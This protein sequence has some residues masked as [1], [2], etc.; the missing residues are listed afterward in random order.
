MANVKFVVT[1]RQK[2]IWLIFIRNAAV[3]SE[4]LPNP[5]RTNMLY[6][7]TRN[8]AICQRYFQLI[9][10]KVPTMHAYAITGKEFYLSEERI[11]KIIAQKH[12][13]A[14]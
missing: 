5:Y 7:Q 13:W 4:P 9:S 11:R 8:K 6:I 1:I 2:Q 3:T 14:K 10:Q 12:K